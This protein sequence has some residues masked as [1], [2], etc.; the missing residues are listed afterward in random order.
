[1]Y[2]TKSMGPSTLPWGIT[3]VTSW[4]ADSAPLTDTFCFRFCR[5]SFTQ[6][7]ILLPM[8]YHCIFLISLLWGTLSKAFMKSIY[9]ESIRLPLSSISVHSS[10]TLRSWSVVDL[11]DINPNCF[12]L[13]ILFLILWSTIRWR[14][15]W[16]NIQG[17][18]TSWKPLT[19]I[20]IEG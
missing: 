10:I 12:L 14:V 6:F 2:I 5:K 19:K 20:P 13:N 17:I 15:Y 16:F 1:M 3:L 8:P 18:W 7:S 9:I 11:P 4:Q